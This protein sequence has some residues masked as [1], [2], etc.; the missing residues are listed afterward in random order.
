M[1]TFTLR[2]SKSLIARLSS[3]AM[4][5][6]LEDFLRD[7]YFLP[8]DPGSGDQRISLTLPQ[9]AVQ[10]ASACLQCSASAALRRIAVEHVADAETKPSAIGTANG[11]Y[12]DSDTNGETDPPTSQ[13]GKIAVVLIHA[14]FAIGHLILLIARRT[15][16]SRD[17]HHI[18]RLK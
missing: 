8:P 5:S 6:W 9:A 13:T 14:I 11:S 10:R 16:K 18:A 15:A 12:S 4:R 1:T 17:E 2:G 3:A 7:P